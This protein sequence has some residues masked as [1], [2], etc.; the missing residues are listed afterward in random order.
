MKPTIVTLCGS[1]RFKDAFTQAQL[2]E[3]LAGRIVLTIGCAMHADPEIFAHLSPEEMEKTKK[4]LDALH[5]RK[6]DISD[7]ILVLNVDG[8]IGDSTSREIAYAFKWVKRIRW[9]H[10]EYQHLP[11]QHYVRWKDSPEFIALAEGKDA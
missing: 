11:S 5:M 6:I 3:T 7:E 8:Y 1:T 4:R 9:L 10:P 2:D